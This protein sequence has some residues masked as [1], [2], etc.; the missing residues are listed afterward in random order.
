MKSTLKI[1]FLILLI[2]GFTSCEKVIELDLKNS[3]QMYVIEGIVEKGETE[4]FVKISKSQ[5]FSD[6]SGFPTVDNAIVVLNDNLGNLETLTL[7]EP[8]LYKSSNLL[9][10]EN[11]TYT[12]TVQIEENTF[13]ASSYMPFQV[14]FDSLTVESLSF[15]PEIVYSITANRLDPLGIE[16]YYQFDVFNSK[17]RIPG[18]IVQNDQF[19]DGEQMLQ[20]IAFGGDFKSGDTLVVAMYCID[21]PIYDY[22]YGLSLNAGGTSGVTPV[23]PES[24][25]GKSCL[26]YF[27]AR[28]K[29]IQ[30]KIIPN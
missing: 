16:N 4:H 5:K 17:K 22:F 23:N 27:S 25:F 21:K 28:T 2:V 11:R 12:I 8:G 7:V 10:V 24:N 1:L 6:A 29:E 9:G 3:A 20:P 15:G 14:P 18:I 30:S 19:S 13:T 26:G